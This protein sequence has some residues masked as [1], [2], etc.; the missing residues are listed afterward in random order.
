MKLVKMATIEQ[1]VYLWENDFLITMNW[2]LLH[3]ETSR[4]VSNGTKCLCFERKF[5]DII[6]YS[7]LHVLSYKPS[8]LDEDEL[9]LITKLSCYLN[10]LK[11][12]K[13][14]I[15]F[16]KL[17]SLELPSLPSCVFV[18]LQYLRNLTFH[19]RKP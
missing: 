10:A 13:Y 14:I 9:S 2:I 11:H 15:F 3:K 12:I 7:S 6:I 5:Q 16:L 1:N 17:L 18:P 4:N 8:N 19:K